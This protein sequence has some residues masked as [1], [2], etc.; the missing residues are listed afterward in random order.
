M[1]AR[2]AVADKPPRSFSMRDL[3]EDAKNLGIEA[4]Y[5]D[6]FGNW[7]TVS[8]ETKER[9]VK[10]LAT[11]HGLES[12]RMESPPQNAAQRAFQGDGRRVWG[13]AV[14]LYALRSRRNW[15]HGDFTDL[16]N[17]VA[18]AARAGAAAV[19]LNPLHALFP[20]RAE[21]SSPYGPNSRLFLNP[22]YIDVEAIPEFSG[23]VGR[24]NE[25]AA[26]R[27]PDFIAY[28]A[29]G[30]LK[31]DALRA[32][33]DA[34]K[35]SASAQRRVD[36]ELYRREQGERLLRFAAFEVLRLKYA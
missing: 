9:L 15:G 18:I 8:A 1:S 20:E 35:N 13:L 36:F 17:L 28:R 19:G 27:Q 34:F 22:L 32:A 21:Q 2:R 26:L 24:E 14:Q 12:S 4:G 25:L 30:R 7:H 11:D 23:L 16:S 29:V 31:L 3:E 10:A 5:H 6:V 33:Y